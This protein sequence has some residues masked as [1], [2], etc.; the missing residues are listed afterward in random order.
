MESRLENV[1]QKRTSI[2]RNPSNGDARSLAAIRQST[3]QA[4]QTGGD[5]QTQSTAQ[6]VQGHET[7]LIRYGFVTDMSSGSPPPNNDAAYNKDTMEY[8]AAQPLICPSPPYSVG[9]HSIPSFH[10]LPSK[11]VALELVNEAFRSFNS[12]YPLFDEQDF[13]KLFHTQYLGSNPSKPAWWACINVVLSLAH[14]L[15]AIHTLETAYET[16]QS[17]KYIHNA[18]AVVSQLSLMHNSLSAVQALVGMAVVIQASPYVY[19]CPSLLATA[20][21]LAQIMGLHRSMRDPSLTE[22]Q[23]EQRKRVFWMAY[24]LDKD[25]SLRMGVPFSQDDN[26]MDVD[27]PTGIVS[28]MPFCHSLY[29]INSFNSRIGLAIIQGQIYRRLYSVQATKLP[30]AQRAAIAQ[31][32]NSVLSYW[33]SGVPI[34]IEDY[35]VTQGPVPTEF[36]HMLVLRFTYINCLAMIDHHLPPTEQLQVDMTSETQRTL[37]SMDSLYILESRKAVRLIKTVPLGNYAYIW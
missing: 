22:S 32:L 19:S 3:D 5:L 23:T 29:A 4:T 13:L 2:E 25:I 30:A 16:I 33:R 1:L 17:C 8:G 31:E 26:D 34:D 36:L 14:R 18:L 27:L 24:F 10:D 21:K 11:T 35:P 7:V 20:L 12:F 28:E 9:M 6:G 15:R 37:A